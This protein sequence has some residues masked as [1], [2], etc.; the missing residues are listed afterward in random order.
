MNVQ[1]G[2]KYWEDIKQSDSMQIQVGIQFH[3]TDTCCTLNESGD[4]LST[5]TAD[6]LSLVLTL[7]PNT[8]LTS[9]YG[10]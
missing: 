4:E 8:V 6:V 3:D 5:M 9:L 2:W 7:A 10:L 1:R